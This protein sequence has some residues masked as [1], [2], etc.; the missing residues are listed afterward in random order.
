MVHM[1]ILSNRAKGA[2]KTGLA[3]S[4]AYGLSLWFGWDK[5]MWAG[6]AVAFVSLTTIGQ[7]FNKA[8]LRMAGTLVGAVASLTL[9]AMFPQQRW[10]F[11]VVFSI[12]IGV[13]TY[14]MGGRKNQYFWHV[15][16]FVCAIIC[17]DAGPDPVNA[18]KMAALRTQETGLGILVYSL[19]AMLLWPTRTLP[20]L[21]TATVT[22]TAAQQN[23]FLA[24]FDL[25]MG[26]GDAGKIQTL[27][28]GVMQAQTRM[29]Q[30]LE[31]ALADSYE[32]KEWEK[33]WT[34]YQ[35]RV[36][37]LSKNLESWRE[38]F[39]EV[40][41][42]NL[43]S[44]I[45]DLNTYRADM[46]ALF[47]GIG[48][49]LAGE[50]AERP[51]LSALTYDQEA[52]KPLTHFQRAA[53]V[54]LVNHMQDVQRLTGELFNLVSEIKG[55]SSETQSIELESNSRQPF[56]FD[57]D[58]G[59]SVFRVMLTVWLAYLAL[60]YVE[61]LPG[62]ASLL[63]M[64]TAIGMVMAVQ[65]HIPV[66]KLFR[67]VTGGILFASVLYIFVMP[68][69]SR[70]LELGGL[71]FLSVFAI[72]YLFH[73]P[74]QGLGR[75]F[76]LAM[77][78]SIMS[79]SN[80]QTY[81]F[82]VVSTTAL[83]F[84]V[85]F[86]VLLITAYIPFSARPNKVILRLLRRYFRSCTYLLLNRPSSEADEKGSWWVAKRKAFHRQEVATLPGKLG[87]W[88]MFLDLKHIDGT[89][90]EEVQRLLVNLQAL[91]YRMAGLPER[92]E[93]RPHPVTNHELYADFQEWSR[94]IQNTM[95]QLSKNPGI[96]NDNQFG[97]QLSAM[98][99]RMEQHIT[100]AIELSD[101]DVPSQEKCIH[102]Y[103]RLGAYRGL[104]EA[105]V[106][107]AGSAGA[108]NWTDWKKERF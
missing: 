8:M 71:I 21:V 86:I 22:Q 16:G 94:K 90:K 33:H 35:R 2:I 74:Q 76:G 105:L 99:H 10:W 9:I 1:K 92:N 42:L 45:P 95:G 12:Y 6:F 89:T 5:P 11:M 31:A 25:M 58:R 47:S 93:R 60:I 62:G 78:A 49:M 41:A 36:F 65:S 98:I 63:S 50:P 68:H 14:M 61:A 57:L 103:H 38:S 108:I 79:V 24:C 70:Y 27:K 34:V 83:M 106:E 29:A 56:V 81:S 84:P 91:S 87:P 4:M 7:S 28:S 20:E 72:C 13:C 53:L 15:C 102:D 54:L 43:A 37:E 44:V 23:L 40:E 75:A 100:E 18:F 88:V 55:F 77:F 69:L 39:T 96:S 32:V 67:P 46:E 30:M 97:D 80:Q 101:G 52:L 19:I 107:Y 82:F 104:S 3:M 85:L 51:Q 26:S 64:A 66:R 73:T 59:L 17:M 48:C